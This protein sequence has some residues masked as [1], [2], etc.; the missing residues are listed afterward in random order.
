MKILYAVTAAKG[1]KSKKSCGTKK[2]DANR[3]HGSSAPYL[4]F[5]I[6]ISLNKME[7]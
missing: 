4:E 3:S 7:A 5:F 1:T 2:A 6:S